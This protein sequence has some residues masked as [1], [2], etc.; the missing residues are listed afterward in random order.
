MPADYTVAVGRRRKRVRANSPEEAARLAVGALT[1]SGRRG[2]GKPRR[3]AEVDGQRFEVYGS[4][5]G[6]YAVPVATD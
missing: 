6:L 2:R 1:G 3:I 5:G 4:A